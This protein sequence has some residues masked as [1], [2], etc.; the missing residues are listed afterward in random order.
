VA[1]AAL[2]ERKKQQTRLDLIRAAIRL[3]QEGG[4][5]ATSVDDI[6]DAA[7]YSKSTFFRYFGSKEDVVFFDLPERLDSLQGTLKLAPDDADP[8]VVARE[9]LTELILSF[10]TQSERELEQACV[11]L[12]FSEPALRR[13]YAEII[14]GWE[15][16]LAEFFARSRNVAPP[17]DIIGKTM[18]SAM[19]GVGRAVTEMQL[20]PPKA[21]EEMIGRGFDLLENGFRPAI[22]PN[23][24]SQ[25]K[26][27][28]IAA[29]SVPRKGAQ[30]R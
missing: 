5:D 15:S 6:I 8:W 14:L 1:K 21:V 29:S 24:N 22:S 4:Y 3:F 2:R 13:R 25:S 18:A 30:S 7:E 19:I 9:A 28:R 10:N 17:T 11:A 26:A 27:S 16:Q 23:G 12:W 20:S